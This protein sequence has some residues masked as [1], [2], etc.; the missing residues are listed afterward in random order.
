MVYWQISTPKDLQQTS[1]LLGIGV[2]F[3]NPSLDTINYCKVRRP[4]RVG[5]LSKCFSTFSIFDKKTVHPCKPRTLA[6]LPQTDLS[7]LISFCQSVKY[8]SK[9]K[10]MTVIYKVLSL[11]QYSLMSY[12]LFKRLVQGTAFHVKV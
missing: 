12:L 10:A 8:H 1:L 4:P 9:R 3:P 6:P 2:S 11:Q 5:C 7:L